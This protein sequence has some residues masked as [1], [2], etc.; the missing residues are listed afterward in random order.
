[1]ANTAPPLYLRPVD[2]TQYC[3]SVSVPEASAGY[4]IQRATNMINRHYNR[5]ACITQYV[6][7]V[8][9]LND[10]NQGHLTFAPVL[11]TSDWSLDLSMGDGI[12]GRYDANVYLDAI[13]YFGKPQWQYIDPSSVDVNPNTGTIWVP[14]GLY[15]VPYTTLRVTYRAGFYDPSL[16]QDPPEWLKTGT[17]M[18]I[19]AIITRSG[20]DQVKD[21]SIADQQKVSFYDPSFFSDSIEE[22]LAPMKAR[23][24]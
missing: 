9:D 14:A 15:G 11:V 23:L 10:R 18:L 13:V 21:Y 5:S 1:M 2:V 8:V 17:G 20:T 6:Q 3:P 7:E 19:E 24:F 22:Q 12:E 16:G 4:L